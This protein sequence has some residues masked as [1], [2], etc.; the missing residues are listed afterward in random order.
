MA[1]AKMETAAEAYRRKREAKQT[2]QRV[3]HP[4]VCDD[5]ECGFEW[6]CERQPIDFWVTSGILPMGLVETMVKAT[7]KAGAADEAIR[8]L[9]ADKIVQSIAFSSKVV[10]HTAIEPKIVDKEPAAVGDNEISREEVMTCCYKKLL[11]WQM[12][13][14][15]GAAALETFR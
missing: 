2:K 7:K 10:L 9:A 14:G 6:Q 5:P 1:T 11:N 13:G 3:L 12:S 15:D 8:T 4:V